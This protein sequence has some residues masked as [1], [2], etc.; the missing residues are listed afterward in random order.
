MNI[1][2]KYNRLVE[3]GFWGFLIS[4]FLIKLPPLYISVVT[5]RLS[6]THILAKIVI[7]LISFFILIVTHK[8]GRMLNYR[9]I[10]VLFF[11]AAQSLSV[12]A[13][14]DVVPFV[15]DYQNV[16]ITTLIFFISYTYGQSNIYVA[17][18]S[19]FIWVVGIVVIGLD[20]GYFLFPDLAVDFLK[21]FAQKEILPVYLVNLDRGRYNLYLNTELF[22]PFFIHHFLHGKD[23]NKYLSLIPISLICF[24]TFV[25]NF[26]HRLLLLLI[27]LILYYVYLT[28][29]N[30]IKKFRSTF[31]TLIIALFFVSIFSIG[32]LYSSR[33]GSINIIERTLL[34]EEA[35]VDSLYTRVDNFYKSVQLMS[36]SPLLGVGL[37]NYQLYMSHQGKYATADSMQSEFNFESENDP[38]SIVSK[39]IAESGLI[40]L[41]SLL[42]MTF[43]FLKKDIHTFIQGDCPSATPYII[44]YWALFALS[45]ITPSISIFRG[46][47]TWVMRGIIEGIYTAKKKY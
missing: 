40:G 1:L 29:G 34:Q 44:A 7:V 37:G 17:K 45:L 5:S 10:S 21:Q 8:K 33:G 13:A 23:K 41:L 26:R 15:K 42:V 2:Y 43:L 47:W 35:D 36:S 16:I 28:I 27:A 38:H 4:I 12:L 6:T 32:L 18:I 11:L 24:L 19:M 22:L 46:G 31:I 39:T 14:S 30:R 9:F 25:S 3:I 20:L